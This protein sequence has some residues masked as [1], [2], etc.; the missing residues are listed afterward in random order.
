[1][2]TSNGDAPLVPGVT[3]DRSEMLVPQGESQAQEPEGGPAQP[4]DEPTL[5]QRFENLKSM[6]E[7][8]ES[9]RKAA[10]GRLRASVKESADMSAMQQEVQALRQLMVAGQ[11]FTVSQDTVAYNE[12]VDGIN[13]DTASRQASFTT[14]KKGTPKCAL[15]PHPRERG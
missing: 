8:S 14:N 6:L 10:E 11:Q 15:S 7:K 5:E 3:G 2:T 13:Q 12:T 1:M 4:G 9:D